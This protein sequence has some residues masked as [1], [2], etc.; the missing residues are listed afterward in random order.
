M[1][2]SDY[3]S[4]IWDYSFTYRP[5]ILF[6][7]DLDIYQHDRDFYIPIEEWGFP[8][9]KSNDEIYSII[10]KFDLDAFV[11]SMN[12]HHTM[13]SSFENANSVRLLIERLNM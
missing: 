3:S 1:L 2:I 12:R 4:T 10:Q 7:P 9:A 5:C 11:Q 6:T 8:I 13:L